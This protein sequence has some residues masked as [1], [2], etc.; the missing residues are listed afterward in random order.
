M[1]KVIPLVICNSCHKHIKD[2]EFVNYQGTYYCEP[3]FDREL[4]EL[5]PKHFFTTSS[6]L[7]EAEIGKH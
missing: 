6:V 3:C 7:F 5:E 1:V 2:V 4:E